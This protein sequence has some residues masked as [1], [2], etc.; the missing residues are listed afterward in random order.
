VAKVFGIGL[1]R[2]GSTSL[3]EALTILG[4]RTVHFPADPVTQR[5]YIRFFAHPGPTLTLR[6]LHQYDAITDTPL[7][8]VYR[9]LDRAYPGSKF[10]W[11]RRD[12]ESWLESCELW[13]A[14]SVMPFMENDHDGVLG[15]FLRLAAE[16]TYGTAR[17][18]A[19]LFSRAYDEHMTGVPEYFRGREH[20]LLA[21]DICAGEGWERLA[22]FLGSAIPDQAFPHR[23]EMVPDPADER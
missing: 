14:R 8:R 23:N 4:Y 22:P 5:E 6:L 1:S 12:K 11:T 13:W 7:P 19:A 20:D 3:A 17:F 10:V 15:P 21:L 18:D 16:A 9:Q 2:T